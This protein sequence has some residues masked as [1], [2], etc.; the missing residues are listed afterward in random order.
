[1]FSF[2][3]NIVKRITF[4]ELILTNVQFRFLTKQ[5]KPAQSHWNVC[6]G[7]MNRHTEGIPRGSR[8]GRHMCCFLNSRAIK[9]VQYCAMHSTRSCHPPW[10]TLHCWLLLSSPH[11]ATLPF[12]FTLRRR[13]TNNAPPL[14]FSPRDWVQVLVLINARVSNSPF[15]PR[16]WIPYL[17][18]SHSHSPPLSLFL[19]LSFS[20][21]LFL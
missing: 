5:T 13:A 3:F 21:S 20:F 8:E 1:M 14:Q 11:A 4:Y 7:D 6:P 15:N 2:S 18:V 16:G 9:S 10:T 12:G 19:S 17:T